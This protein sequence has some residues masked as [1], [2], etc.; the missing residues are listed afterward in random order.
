VSAGRKPGTKGKLTSADLVS[1][2]LLSQGPAHG[3]EIWTRL[4]A[5]DVQDWAEVSR[6]QVY[7]SLGKLAERGMIRAVAGE[8]RADRRTWRITAEGQRA[9]TDSLSASHWARNRVV[10]PFITWLAL[11]DHAWPAVRDRIID[12]R[13]AFLNAEVERERATLDALRRIPSS[14]RG[15]IIARQMVE[16]V[17]QQFVLELDWLEDLELEPAQADA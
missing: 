2:G 5:H 7:Y 6:A 3:H 15:V 16:L 1:L 8:G 11:S 14:E 13:R 4:A 12:E 9:L 17:I 10:S